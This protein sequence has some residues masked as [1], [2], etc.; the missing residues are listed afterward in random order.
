MGGDV[1]D[2][3]RNKHNIRRVFEEGFT[4]GRLEVV[5]ECIAPDGIDRHEFD[6]GD[7]FPAHLKRTITM[8][9]SAFPDLTMTVA[10]IVGEGDRVAARVVL[11][12]THTGASFFGIPAA[13]RPVEVEQFHFMQCD[14]AGL[15]RV[16]WANVGLEDLV[17][18]LTREAA[19][20]V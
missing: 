14:A 3:Q 1:V 13:G 11:A 12:G 9:R 6:P 18:Q 16:H 17:G 5:D 19:P 2:V 20:A 4:L 15:G 8:L 7:D 10:D